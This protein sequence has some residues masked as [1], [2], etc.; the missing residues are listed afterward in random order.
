MP[1][2]TIQLPISASDKRDVLTVSSE[3]KFVDGSFQLPPSFASK[4]LFL[5]SAAELSYQWLSNALH[6]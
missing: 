5:L 6:S 1:C 2:T 4:K 3:T